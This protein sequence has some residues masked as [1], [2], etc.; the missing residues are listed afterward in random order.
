M[1]QNTNSSLVYGD[2]PE[3]LNRISESNKSIAI[4][5]RDIDF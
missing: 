5:Q 4:V 1:V 2:T 3:I